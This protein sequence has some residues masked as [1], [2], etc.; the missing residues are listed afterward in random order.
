MIGTLVAY[1]DV[2]GIR[3]YKEI[4]EIVT[5]AHDADY[6]SEGIKCDVETLET[7]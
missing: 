3:Q 2:F 4:V 1:L 7:N 5:A 6:K